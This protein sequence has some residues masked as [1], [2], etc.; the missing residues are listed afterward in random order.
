MNNSNLKHKL[1]KAHL[2]QLSHEEKGSL[3]LRFAQYMNLHPLA[4]KTPF[5]T[6]LRY[7]SVTA[8]TA[9]IFL[10]SGSLITFASQSSL[11]GELLYPIK[12]TSEKVKRATIKNPEQKIAY[13]LALL[14]K[15]YTETNTLI[16]EHSLDQTKETDITKNI[17]K[18]ISDIQ[19]EN[20][21]IAKTNPAEALS[22]N[23]KL[24]Q[25]LKT[26]TQV[27]LAVSEKN[28]SPLLSAKNTL[29][30]DGPHAKIVLAAYESAAKISL[31]TEQ[32]QQIVLSD[33]DIITVKTAEKKYQEILPRLTLAL[34]A[35]TKI[36]P[37]TTEPV[38]T[39]KTT[40]E[41]VKTAD[42]KTPVTTTETP[43]K[44]P[45]PDT[46]ASLS[47]KLHAAYDAKEYNQ[48]IVIADQIDQ[49]LS[50]AEKIKRAEKTYDIVVPE[51][52]DV[53]TPADTVIETPTTLEKAPELKPTTTTTVDKK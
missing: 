33:T 12:I 15:R 11:P 35:T 17:Q 22:F 49:K 45:E 46:L 41:T 4:Q 37:I 47:E 24:A 1:S 51:T 21:K 27:L 5:Y 8:F 39:E 9:L 40:I 25:A 3:R 38:V 16:A 19:T 53:K 32:L 30:N 6:Y 18:N 43:A 34:G 23:S 52:T 26:N 14:E 2:I 42:I 10:G 48:V 36:T 50:E 7:A 20:E 29:V 31:K 44:Q 13:S 28:Q